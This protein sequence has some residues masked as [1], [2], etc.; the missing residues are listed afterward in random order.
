MREGVINVLESRQV[1]I[2][3][4]LVSVG[5]ALGPYLE[6]T[7]YEKKY[8]DLEKSFDFLSDNFHL[9]VNCGRSELTKDGC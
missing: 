1:R 2:R 7:I 5:R 3:N 9:S 4:P 6:L 8:R